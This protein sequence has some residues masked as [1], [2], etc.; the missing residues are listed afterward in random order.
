MH[1]TN[2]PRPAVLCALSALL[3]AGPVA[4]AQQ[5]EPTDADAPAIEPLDTGWTIRLEPFA[6]YIGPAGDVRLPS[7]TTRGG[8]VKLEDLNLDSPRLVP[9]GRIQAKR[10]K[11]KLGFSGLAFSADDRGAIQTGAGQ[12]GSIAYAAGDRLITDLA[13]ESFDLLVSYRIWAHTSNTNAAGRTRLDAGVDL[14]GGLRFHHAE[15][16][17]R[18]TPAVAPPPGTPLAA[19][20][21][22]FFIEP[23]VGARLDLALLEQFGIEVEST[24]GGFAMGDRSS[25][26]FSIDAG[27]AYRPTPSVGVKVG[28]RLLVFNLNDDDG[29]REFEWSGSMAGLYAGLQLSF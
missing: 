13:Y 24:A 6:G 15:F 10:G 14:I 27:F 16:D 23:V 1:A 17:V 28:Y 4:R 8:A 22:E 29:A 5:S 7:T 18:S 2:S 3:A 20:A 11:W 21:D 25:F 19:G 26:S 12:L 9:M